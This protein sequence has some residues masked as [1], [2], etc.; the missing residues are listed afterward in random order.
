MTKS[1][2]RLANSF[3]RIPNPSKFIC[4]HLIGK[5]HRLIHRVIVGILIMI[6]GVYLT[7]LCLLSEFLII[8]VVGDTIGFL[9]HGVGA[10]PIVE[11]F[12]DMN[13]KEFKEDFSTNV[14]ND[15]ENEYK[16]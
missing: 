10:I 15:N 16:Q 8:H 6:S 11:I 4:N 1:N 12:L 3:K 5:E 14:K 9:V 7:K 2:K 13:S